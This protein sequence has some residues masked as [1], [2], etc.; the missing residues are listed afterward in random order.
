MLDKAEQPNSSTPGNPN[1]DYSMIKKD[2]TQIAE[3]RRQKR[4]REVDKLV[5]RTMPEEGLPEMKAE[6]GAEGK[7][8]KKALFRK[9]DKTSS[10][11]DYEERNDDDEDV[12]D[13]EVDDE[14]PQDR[15]FFQNFTLFV[16]FFTKHSS[17][18]LFQ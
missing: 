6:E 10:G 7:P 1:P 4:I 9:I 13:A 18:F 15:F 17:F 12:D 5:R 16:F 2:A 14:E 3:E 8:K 11:M